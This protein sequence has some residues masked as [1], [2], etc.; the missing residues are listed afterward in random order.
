ML[1]ATNA[2]RLADSENAL[3]DLVRRAA[4][5]L[6]RRGGALPLLARLTRSMAQA[7]RWLTIVG[8]MPGRSFED[9]CRH[10][11]RLDVLL[12]EIIEK[13]DVVCLAHGLPKGFDEVTRGVVA[14]CSFASALSAAPRGPTARSLRTPDSRAA[15]FAHASLLS[16]IKG[17]PEGVAKGGKRPLGG[18]GLGAFKRNSCA[19]PG[20][21]ALPSPVPDP[22]RTILMSPARTLTR[23]LAV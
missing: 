3:V 12:P 1:L 20:V 10:A 16:V 4:V 2:L 9:R 17:K 11:Q 6:R 15:H 23:T 8:T 18:I 13:L 19:C 5:P 14:R 7:R 22:S 21:E